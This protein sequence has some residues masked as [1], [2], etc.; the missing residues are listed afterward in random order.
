MVEQFERENRGPAWVKDGVLQR[1]VNGQT[2]SP[3]YP[4]YTPEAGGEITMAYALGNGVSNSSQVWTIQREEDC[5]K[6][7]EMALQYSSPS[8][9]GR[10]D[11]HSGVLEACSAS[12]QLF[13][14]T[15]GAGSTSTLVDKSSGMCL[16]TST[17]EQ[18][19][20]LFVEACDSSNVRQQ[21]LV[22]LSGKI[23]QGEFCMTVVDPNG[24]SEGGLGLPPPQV[25]LPAP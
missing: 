13:E 18:G 22:G 17:S 1:R 6:G 9:C 25:I 8:L 4:H 20:S 21:W 2:Y 16:A 15:A 10:F 19:S 11:G 12:S 14:H 5:S 3:N 7:C 23:W 24:V